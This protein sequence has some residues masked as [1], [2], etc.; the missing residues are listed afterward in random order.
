MLDKTQIRISHKARLAKLPPSTL[1]TSGKA[2]AKRAI[3]LLKKLKVKNVLLYAPLPYEPEILAFRKDLSSKGIKLFL[4]FMVDKSLKMVK[5]RLPFF[6]GRFNVRQAAPSNA[7]IPRLDAALIPVIGV[8]ADLA[9]IGHGMGFYDRFFAS[10]K[11]L[12]KIIFISSQDF[13]VNAKICEPHDIKGDFY[14]S[15]KNIR[16]NHDRNH[17]S[18]GYRRLWRG[19]WLFSG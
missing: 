6:K 10:L 15:P 19:S 1:K 11:H 5:L 4:P 12:P 7:Y 13:F 8:D 14:V 9:R 17:R 16:T 3:F 2:S 18:G